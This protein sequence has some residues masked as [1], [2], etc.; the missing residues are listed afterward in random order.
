[1]PHLSVKGEVTASELREIGKSVLRDRYFLG[2]PG[3]GNLVGYIGLGYIRFTYP[4]PEGFG[5]P[6]DIDYNLQPEEVEKLQEAL[7]RRGL[8]VE[9]GN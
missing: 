7:C 8:V 9:Y 5:W 3:T 2:V 4:P 1:M 6:I